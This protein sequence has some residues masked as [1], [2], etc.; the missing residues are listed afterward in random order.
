MFQMARQE[1]QWG[2]NLRR[3]SSVG[4]F[5]NC[6]HYCDNHGYTAGHQTILWL[7]SWHAIILCAYH[8]G[9]VCGGVVTRPRYGMHDSPFSRLVQFHRWLMWMR[10]TGNAVITSVSGPQL[11]ANWQGC[12]CHALNEMHCVLDW[13]VTG[14]T[15]QWSK[16]RLIHL[17]LHCLKTIILFSTYGFTSCLCVT[18]FFD[19]RNHGNPL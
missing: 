15:L 8:L 4:A 14:Q 12:V 13:P 3:Y 2:S 5:V 19:L 18:W 10:G 11:L 16:N 6:M 17:C 7:C 1:S 9:T